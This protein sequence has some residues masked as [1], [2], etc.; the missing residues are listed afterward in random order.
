MSWLQKTVHRASAGRPPQAASTP[1]APSVAA[2]ASGR[3]TRRDYVYFQFGIW[4]FFWVLDLLSFI[5]DASPPESKPL[6]VVLN[7]VEIVLL[8]LCSHVIWRDWPRRPGAGK[9][10]GRIACLAGATLVTAALF[11]LYLMA[12]ASA[13]GPAPYGNV[14][15]AV[16]NWIRASIALILWTGFYRAYYYRMQTRRLETECAQLQAATS[17]AQLLAL[18]GQLNPHFLFNSLNTLRALIQHDPS[19]ARR[20]TTH[21]ADMMRYSLTM[22]GHPVIPLSA[23]LDFI[24]DY[25]ALERLRHEERLRIQKTITPAA[26]GADI[27]PMLLQ[28]LVEN[29]VKHGLSQRVEG[30]LVTCEITIE[31]PPDRPAACARLRLRV[32]NQGSLRPASARLAASRPQGTGLRNIRERLRLLYGDDASLAVTQ[33]GGLVVAEAVLPSFARI[34]ARDPGDPGPGGQPLLST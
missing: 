14:V 5:W 33:Q 31:S 28:T 18:K 16:G 17:E 24:N 4:G 7:T 27:P 13:P 12:Y 19:A 11:P 20:A 26:L 1:G 8:G 34:G 2:A 30:I 23:E 10:R 22:S 15:L 25:L 32:T 21:L 6:L 9:A 3:T 29:A